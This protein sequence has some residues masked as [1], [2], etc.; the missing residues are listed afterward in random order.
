MILLDNYCGSVC[1][2]NNMLE[3]A[4]KIKNEGGRLYLVGRGY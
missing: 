4:R 2:N 1:M 3:I